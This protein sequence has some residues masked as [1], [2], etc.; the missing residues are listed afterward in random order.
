[1]P[2]VHFIPKW[3]HKRTVTTIV[4]LGFIARIITLIPCFLNVLFRLGLW[5]DY[6][7]RLCLSGYWNID[8]LNGIHACANF[9][10]YFFIFSSFFLPNH[11]VQKCLSY[12]V[13]KFVLLS[14]SQVLHLCIFRSSFVSQVS[15][16][17]VT[18]TQI[19]GGDCHLF[20]S[21]DAC[22]STFTCARS[23]TLLDLSKHS[24]SAA[25]KDYNQ[26]GWLLTCEMTQQTC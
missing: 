10:L 25:V 15:A 6:K 7:L 3:G 14:H 20:T 21:S 1:M 18:I 11:F 26:A 12:S 9:L 2:D 13:K 16:N 19:S 5:E 22:S 17:D 24:A 23:C 4:C 8:V